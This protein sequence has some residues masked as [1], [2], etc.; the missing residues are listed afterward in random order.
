MFLQDIAQ[1]AAHEQ[2]RA[3]GIVQKLDG[4]VTLA[5][6]LEIDSERVGHHAAPPT[7]PRRKSTHSPRRA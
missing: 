3:V 6:P 4:V 1:A 5:L 7:S 2:T